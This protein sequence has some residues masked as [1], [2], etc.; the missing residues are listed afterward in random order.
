[1]SSDR[2]RPD[3]TSLMPDRIG[4]DPIAVTLGPIKSNPTM[5]MT[6]D[7]IGSDPISTIL[8]RIRSDVASVAT[9][10]IGPQS[11]P[12][13]RRRHRI[14]ILA[15]PP[16]RGL[17]TGS[18]VARVPAGASR[19]RRLIALRDPHGRGARTLASGGA[20]PH[21]RSSPTRGRSP[22]FGR[23]ARAESRG[24]R[25]PPSTFRLRAGSRSPPV[26]P[27]VRGR[28]RDRP[29]VPRRAA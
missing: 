6:S 13:S 21:E 23:G 29:P 9:T 12:L 8:D 3:L 19:P 5:S 25:S 24:G 1:M 26:A 20:S 22:L 28:D 17:G 4:S 15:S 2:I 14:T 27:R 10:G 18:G 16:T 7:P 11:Y